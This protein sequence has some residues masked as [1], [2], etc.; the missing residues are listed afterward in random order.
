MGKCVGG[1]HQSSWWPKHEDYVQ[2]LVHWLSMHGSQPLSGLS[3]VPMG[4]TWQISSIVG[5]ASCIMM[6]FISQAMVATTLVTRSTMNLRFCFCSLIFLSHL[7]KLNQ[8]SVHLISQ[9]LAG[10]AATVV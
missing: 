4:C 3:S 6:G 5:T 2:A 10:L 8:V 1:S 9:G 7:E